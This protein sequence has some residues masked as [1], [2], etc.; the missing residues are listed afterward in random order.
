ME[1]D[2]GDLN[3]TL[4]SMYLS[5]SAN[6][7]ADFIEKADDFA[8]FTML[9]SALRKFDADEVDGFFAT[10]EKIISGLIGRQANGDAI[11]RWFDFVTKYEFAGRQGFD[12]YHDGKSCRAF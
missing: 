8:D 12:P 10:M 11:C 7:L 1:L 5:V 3:A 4:I 2:D 6:C 9:D